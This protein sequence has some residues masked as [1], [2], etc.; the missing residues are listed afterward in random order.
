MAT[1]LPWRHAR[2]PGSIP[3][4]LRRLGVRYKRGR[5]YFHS[6]DLAYDAK[7]AAITAAQLLAHAHPEAMVL[8]YEAE[9]TYYRRPSLSRACAPAA[10]DAPRA[11]QG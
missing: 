4:I 11:D 9:F 8:L 6:P 5:A 10:T 1:G 7:L 3:R 2:A